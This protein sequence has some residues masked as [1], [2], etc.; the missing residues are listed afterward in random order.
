MTEVVVGTVEMSPVLR[1]LAE[2]HTTP[3]HDG[4]T[5]MPPRLSETEKERYT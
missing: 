3:S 4:A 2:D 1:E 5:E